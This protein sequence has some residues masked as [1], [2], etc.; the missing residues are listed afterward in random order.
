MVSAEDAGKEVGDTDDRVENIRLG[1]SKH[2]CKL[3]P[4]YRRRVIVF[5]VST[6]FPG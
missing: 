6:V 1:T 2:G 3:P 5:H 4:S